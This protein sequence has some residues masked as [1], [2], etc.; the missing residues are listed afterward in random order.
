MLAAIDDVGSSPFRGVFG[1]FGVG[2]AAVAILEITLSAIIRSAFVAI[3]FCVLVFFTIACTVLGNQ[4]LTIGAAT[5]FTV[6]VVVAMHMAG[7]IVRN[8]GCLGSICGGAAFVAS[9]MLAATT[10]A[11]AATTVAALVGVAV[12]IVFG[13]GSLGL[14]AQQRLTVGDRYLIV[15]GMDFAERQETVAIAAILD[16]GGLKRWFD[17]RHARQ[18]DVSLELFLVL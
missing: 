16:E 2:G 17:A 15:V 12:L 9:A 6:V 13:F 4:R 1:I 18:V 8:L 3:A 10:P 5:F 7:V 11:P 14:G